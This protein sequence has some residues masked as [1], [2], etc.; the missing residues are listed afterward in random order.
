MS[1]SIDKLLV[2]SGGSLGLASFFEYGCR[3]LRTIILARLLTPDAFGLAA[4]L[5]ACVAVAEALTEVG[6]REAVVQNK[7]GR[8]REFLSTNWW[9]SLG[10]GMLIYVALWTLAPW[11]TKTFNQEHAVLMLRVGFLVTLLN[12]AT[13]PALHVL[14]KDF[15]FGKWVLL[16]QVSGVVGVVVAIVLGFITRSVWALIA[17]AVAESLCRCVLSF[18]VLPFRPMLRISREYLKEITTFSRG[19]FGLPIL[20]VILMQT[21]T[22]V[23]GKLFTASVLGIYSLARDLA[24]LPNKV[25]SRVISPLLLP[26]FSAQQEDLDGMRKRVIMVTEL[27]V[28][29]GAPYTLFC[30]LFGEPYLVTVYGNNVVGMAGAFSMLSAA[31]LLQ[32]LSSVIMN[33]F[34]GLGQPQVQRLAS[35]ARTVS[36]LVI[37][38]PLARYVGASGVAL[39]VLISITI[40]LSLQVSFAR[41]ILGLKLAEYLAPWW[42]GLRLC[43]FVIAAWVLVQFVVVASW[44]AVLLGCAGF[45]TS[46]AIACLRM[47]AFQRVRAA[48]AR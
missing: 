19:M 21:D 26:T 3:F 47:E 28:A 23:M 35:L 33:A 8:E 34:I 40:A 16:V 1:E 7:H 31:I 5:V 18:A 11:V 4:L 2:R 25:L 22:F 6:L 17:G 14:Q 12:A 32:I 29:L 9:L 20:M 44:V 27:L 10:R 42:T 46:W 39:A 15:S 30:I 41:R 45:L 36:V 38:Y 43:S 37:I 24:D 13:S 48:L